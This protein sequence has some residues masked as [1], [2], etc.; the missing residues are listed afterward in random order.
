MNIVTMF[1]NISQNIT[2]GFPWE[3]SPKLVLELRLDS[4]RVAAEDNSG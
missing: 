3:V 1:F 2:W 4:L